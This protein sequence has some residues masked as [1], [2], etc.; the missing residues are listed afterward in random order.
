M[1]IPHEDA[2]AYEDPPTYESPVRTRAPQLP[3]LEPLPSIQVTTE[4]TPVD[5]R[6]EGFDEGLERR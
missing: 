2:P 6:G 3:L 4:P 5:G 1:E